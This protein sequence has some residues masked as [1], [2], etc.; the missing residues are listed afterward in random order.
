[1][2]NIFRSDIALEHALDGVAAK[3]QIHR[4]TPCHVSVQFNHIRHRSKAP[5]GSASTRPACLISNTSA[6]CFTPAAAII[7]LVAA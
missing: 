4:N 3:N 2:P 7:A 6:V 1:M 5:T